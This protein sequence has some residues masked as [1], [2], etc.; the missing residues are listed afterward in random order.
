MESLRKNQIREILD[1]DYNI[2]RQVVNRQRK[3]VDTMTDNVVPKRMR[4]LDIEVNSDKIVESI[5]EK[6]NNKLATLESVLSG[7]LDKKSEIE[8]IDTSIVSGGW[9]QLV[10]Y[11]KTP[12]LSRQS[13]EIL[14][15]KVQ[16]LSTNID[17]MVYGLSKLSE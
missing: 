13:Q 16:D 14:K 12:S 9:N 2:S 11:Y 8:L 1:A 5:N 7:N 4:D 15:I 10:R 6:L 17:A 3:Q